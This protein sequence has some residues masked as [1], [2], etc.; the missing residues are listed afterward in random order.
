MKLQ[1]R[2]EAIVSLV[3]QRGTISFVELKKQFN[4]SE[5]TLRRDLEALDQ[6]RR[7]VRIHGGAKSVD[8]VVGTDDLF[9][10]RSGR[11]QEAKEI[12]ARKALAF[13]RPGI[14]IYL[15]SGT[16]TTKLAAQMPDIPCLIFTNS[17]TCAS[18]LSRLTQPTVH[19]LG[20][21]L[22]AASLST[23]G[24]RSLEWVEKLNFDVAFMGATGYASGR[25][26]TC[27]SE[28]ECLL[29]QRVIQR[30]E[31]TLMLMDSSKVGYAYPFSIAQAQ[32]MDVWLVDDDLPG[33]IRQEMIRAGLQVV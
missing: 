30:S 25:G 7:I 22:N 9:A 5:M 27:G 17:L 20:G 13:I 21:C 3:N 4:T 26:F 19:L 18:A 8:V 33:A 11:S 2:R 15:D 29:K 16:T 10:R 28:E 23:H 24:G 12:I 32:E 14:A 1:Q 6:Q 31:K